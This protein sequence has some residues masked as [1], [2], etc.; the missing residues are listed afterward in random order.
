MIAKAEEIKKEKE[1]VESEYNQ[2]SADVSQLKM[3]RDFL[4]E[5]NEGLLENQRQIL[6][7]NKK[8]D[9]ELSEKYEEA[10]QAEQII[11]EAENA[12]RELNCRTYLSGVIRN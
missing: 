8:Y 6:E 5:K 12:K 7:D 9:A 11:S 1:K 2:L 10:K 4:T 3:N